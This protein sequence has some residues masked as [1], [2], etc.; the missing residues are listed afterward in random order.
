MALRVFKKKG[1]FVHKV[2]KFY[3]FAQECRFHY[4]FLQTKIQKCCTSGPTRKR[5]IGK[6]V[7]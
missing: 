2:A 1:V 6:V 5:D 7:V 4:S 3:N